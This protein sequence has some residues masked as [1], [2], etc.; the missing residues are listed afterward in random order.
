MR[1]EILRITNL[2]KLAN[3]IYITKLC[4]NNTIF[5]LAWHS[6]IIFLFSHFLAAWSSTASSE[7]NNFVLFSI[8]NGVIH[9]LY[10]KICFILVPT[11]FQCYTLFLYR[12]HSFYRSWRIWHTRCMCV[13]V[14]VYRWL[15]RTCLKAS[16]TSE[17][18][19]CYYT[20]EWLW[21]T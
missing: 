13:C 9:S 6:S 12:L 4:K 19:S 17:G 8:K 18:H 7:N 5:L 11:Y 16:P 10:M 1:K 20:H 21:T 15:E 3:A 14:C 2:K